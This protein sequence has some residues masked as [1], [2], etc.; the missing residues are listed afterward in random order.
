VLFASKG[1]V[2]KVAFF[3]V[4]SADT[5]MLTIKAIMDTKFFIRK[6]VLSLLMKMLRYT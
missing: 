2:W 3:Q 6:R 5:L 4:V 1:I